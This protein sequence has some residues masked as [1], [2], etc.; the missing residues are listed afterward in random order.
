[1]LHNG[2]GRGVA[3]QFGK[4]TKEKATQLLLKQPSRSVAATEVMR[5]STVDVRNP[6]SCLRLLITKQQI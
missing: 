5:K 6:H 2:R 4:Y 1:M 3:E